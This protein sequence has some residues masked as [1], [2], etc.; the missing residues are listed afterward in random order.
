MSDFTAVID[1]DG[2]D[3]K[4]LNLKSGDKVAIT[5]SSHWPV[6]LNFNG[7]FFNE[8]SVPP[9]GLGGAFYNTYIASGTTRT[10]EASNVKTADARKNTKAHR[11]QVVYEGRGKTLPANELPGP[12]DNWKTLEEFDECVRLKGDDP[13][14]I[15]E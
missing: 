10:L 2:I 1:K 7:N 8:L 11:Y 6:T 15:I 12:H 3:P 9:G 13:H 4:L 5:N 14:L